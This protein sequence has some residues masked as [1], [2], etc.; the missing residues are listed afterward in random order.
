MGRVE[1]GNDM[2]GTQRTVIQMG[3]RVRVAFC[4]EYFRGRAAGLCLKAAAQF[5][6]RGDLRGQIMVRC[7]S[8][9]QARGP[10][11]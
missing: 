3:T 5:E 10:G 4:D 6:N 2:H 9:S 8:Q 1:P 11:T 7:C